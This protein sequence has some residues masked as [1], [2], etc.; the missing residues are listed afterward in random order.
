[1]WCETHPNSIPFVSGLI[2][3]SYMKTTEEYKKYLESK[4]EHYR[5]GMEHAYTDVHYNLM[6]AKWEAINE[7]YQ[8]VK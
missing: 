7:I 3:N 1:M 8:E 2:Y 6:K 4:L 5:L